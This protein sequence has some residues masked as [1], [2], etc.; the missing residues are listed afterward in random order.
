MRDKKRSVR[1]M[2]T[3]QAQRAACCRDFEVLKAEPL[4]IPLAQLLRD[5]A[6]KLSPYSYEDQHGFVVLVEAQVNPFAGAP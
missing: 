3:C 4:G 2:A 5:K 6:G 1:G